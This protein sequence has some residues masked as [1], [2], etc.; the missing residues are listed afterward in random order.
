M[1]HFLD[2]IYCKTLPRA[3]VNSERAWTGS[4]QTIVSSTHAG[5]PGCGKQFNSPRLSNSLPH[6]FNHD[7]SRI[8]NNTQSKRLKFTPHF[9]YSHTRAQAHARWPELILKAFPFGLFSLRQEPPPVTIT[10]SETHICIDIGM[11]Q[12][13][14][15]KLYVFL[16]LPTKH[17]YKC[18][19]FCGCE[20]LLLWIVAVEVM[21]SESSIQ[22]NSHPRGKFNPPWMFHAQ[23]LLCVRLR[24]SV[25]IPG[26]SV[27]FTLRRLCHVE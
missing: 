16:N 22:M 2:S 18:S 19:Q 5:R 1:W 24:L 9:S 23:E 26:M 15:N 8:L 4:L 3:R 20:R 10:A 14:W 27:V 13:F 11:H 25:N 7:I 12:F 21:D 17:I 6:N